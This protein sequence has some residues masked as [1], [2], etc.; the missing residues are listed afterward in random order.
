MGKITKRDLRILNLI[1]DFGYL[2]E[3]FFIIL[4]HSRSNKERSA[5]AYK[6]NSY[7]DKLVKAELVCIKKSDLG[8]SYYSLAPRGRTYLFEKGVKTYPNNLV[9][10]NGK[11]AHSRLCSKVY[12]KIA[13]IYDVKF[14]SENCL[15]RI[16][17]ST[18]VPDL[19]V[20]LGGSI[21]YFEIERSLKSEVLIK[22][23]LS[24]YNLKFGDGYLI[25]LTES[26]SIIKK[27]EGLKLLYTN[28]KRILAHDLNKFMA[29]PMFYL[30]DI[31]TSSLGGNSNEISINM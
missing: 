11:F 4:F 3:D 8:Y 19:A 25:Y 27:I 10:D 7:L 9:I 31:W 5:I 28:H 14:K 17:N 26:D 20:R 2:D 29:N 18:I 21:I 23:K 15:V 24:N 16:S 22:E 6:V 30:K 13:S 12:A 1:N